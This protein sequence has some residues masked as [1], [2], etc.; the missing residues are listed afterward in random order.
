M[1]DLSGK[2]AL[3]TGASRGIGRATAVELARA[4]ARVAVHYGA[5]TQAAKETV[6]AIEAEGGAA[7]TLQADLAEPGGADALIDAL[8]RE[9]RGVPLDILVN[10]AGIGADGRIGTVS[11]DDY[12]RVFAVN[13]KSP[14]FITR[15][16]LELIPDGGRIINIGSG[17]TRIA[18]PEAIAY[19]MT[20]GA[21]DTFTLALAA[22]LG[23]RGITVNTVAPGIT[24]TDLNPWL[25]DPEAQAAAAARAALGRVGRPEDVTGPILFLASEA[26]RWTTGQIIDATGGSHL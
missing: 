13:A 8:T 4:G 26:G 15:R 19:A 10:N 11:E 20:K 16:S 14:F 7:F 6:A 5:N 18:L 3:V 9:L 24:D 1:F 23:P 17:V 12:D 2:T 22:E 21:V 25:R